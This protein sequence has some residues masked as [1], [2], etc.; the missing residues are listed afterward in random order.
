MRPSE[1]SDSYHKTVVL[2]DA[3]GSP[4]GAASVRDPRFL[5]G[6]MLAGR[7]RIVALLG[8]GGMGRVYRADDLKL[9]QTQG[10]YVA[11]VSQRGPRRPRA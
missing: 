9:G 3:P 4:A 5:P 1:P 6:E 2:A 7:Y 11:F 10:D 8:E